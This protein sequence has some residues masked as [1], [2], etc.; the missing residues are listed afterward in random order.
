LTDM[1]R[2]VPILRRPIAKDLSA[3]DFSVQTTMYALNFTKCIDLI[4]EHS[5]AVKRPLDVLDIGCGDMFVLKVLWNGSYVK[6]S[7]VLGT[8]LGMDIADVEIPVGS[9]TD[10]V[11]L[12][13]IRRDFMEDQSIPLADVD[14]VVIHEFLEH[15]DR[16]SSIEVLRNVINCIRPGGKLYLSTPNDAMH[17]TDTKYHMH[18]YGLQEI[19]DILKSFGMEIDFITGQ[20]ARLDV[21]SKCLES[22][23]GISKDV[24][25]SLRNR[26][27]T[28][29]YRCILATMFPEFSEGLTIYATKM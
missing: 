26:L 14:F 22:F 28:N 1:D 17:H 6:K 25:Q 13:F 3:G 29:Y 19:V 24:L 11:N 2:T 27:S 23:Y 21:L 20:Y 9:H 8:Y 5:K 10:G 7:T 18:Q 15:I 16:K 4:I 12:Q